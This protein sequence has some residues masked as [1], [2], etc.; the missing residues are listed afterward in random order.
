MVPAER[1]LQLR[2]E[3][4]RIRRKDLRE[5]RIYPA[6]DSNASRGLSGGA[7]H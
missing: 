4:E 1:A 2:H 5:S 6:Q 3:S 7:G